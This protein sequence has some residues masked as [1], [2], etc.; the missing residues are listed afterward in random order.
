MRAG[1]RVTVP[2]RR[3]CTRLQSLRSWVAL[4]RRGE[5]K[6][7]AVGEILPH[8]TQNGLPNRTSQLQGMF[9][10]KHPLQTIRTNAFRWRAAGRAL[11][12]LC[13][14][15]ASPDLTRLR[16]SP[17]LL[18]G[19]YARR[20]WLGMFHVKHPQPPTASL[21]TACSNL[22]YAYQRPSLTSRP[23][24]PK[25]LRSRTDVSRETS[26]RDSPGRLIRPTDRFAAFSFDHQ[27]RN[28]V[29][30]HLNLQLP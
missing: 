2:A 17:H 15:S 8:A 11:S 30:R 28:G 4:N 18:A 6:T 14:S 23:L 26:V 19:L 27:R 29:N 5:V 1:L 24:P 7:K 3:R 10:V 21:A 12:H 20:K 13:W 9:H 16:F 22:S 25:F